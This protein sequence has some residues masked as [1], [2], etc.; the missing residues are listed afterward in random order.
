MKYIT[1][2]LIFTVIFTSCKSSKKIID[3]NSSI[4]KIS[5]R[6]VVKKH[7]AS[8]FNKKTVD[9]KLKVKFKN[10]KENKTFS[11][12]MKIKKDEVIWLRGIYIITVFKAKI[13]PT[14]VSYYSPHFKDYFEGDFSVLKK[15]L[16]VDINFEQ[17]QNM[18]LGQSLLDIKSEKQNVEI[19]EQ[20]Y[21]LSP[22]KQPNL[23]DIFFFV[24][25]LNFKLNKQTL[26]NT[27]KNQQLDIIYP[28]YSKIKNTLFPKKIVIKAKE[29]N[30]LTTIDMLV[31]SVLFNSNVNIPFKIP[32]GYKKIK[33]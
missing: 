4:K 17:L 29:S 12:R 21:R 2:L 8:N 5:A 9:A 11:V 33:F 31:K 6:K 13:T 19:V 16:G 7:I 14:K 20:S 22:K 32:S 26:V 28:E 27:L 24:N 18:L 10:A 30:T 23:F 15:L 1:Y 25:P 3:N